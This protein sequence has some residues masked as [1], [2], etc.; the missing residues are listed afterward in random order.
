MM[1]MMMMTLLSARLAA[2]DIV[3]MMERLE[4]TAGVSQRVL[5]SESRH[6][7]QLVHNLENL[8]YIF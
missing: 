2:G 6:L 7:S 3:S 8:F 1:I 5:A 4:Q